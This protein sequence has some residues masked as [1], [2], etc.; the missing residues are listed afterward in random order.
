MDKLGP[1]EIIFII[2]VFAFLASFAELGIV[3]ATN[4]LGV[5]QFVVAGQMIASILLIMFVGAIEIFRDVERK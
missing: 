3:S 5:A 4:T 2:L 1:L